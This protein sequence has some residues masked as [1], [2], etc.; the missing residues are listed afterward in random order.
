MDKMILFS[1]TPGGNFSESPCNGCGGRCC[2]DLKVR[3]NEDNL[4]TMRIGNRVEV[5]EDS[6]KVL[7]IAAMIGGLSRG[8]HVKKEGTIYKG[9]LVGACGNLNNNGSCGVEDMKP[10][11]CKN[12]P[13]DGEL[14][15]MSRMT[16]GP[17]TERL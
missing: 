2:Q 15:Q 14:C 3:L 4:Q 11:M 16:R 9:V 13:V 17:A 5:T 1:N 6:P 12:E 8:V 10:T 7:E